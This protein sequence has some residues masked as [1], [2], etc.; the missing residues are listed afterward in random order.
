MRTAQHST[1][2][3]HWHNRFL[4]GIDELCRHLQNEERFA[5]ATELIRSIV[6]FHRATMQTDSLG[7]ASLSS[8][9]FRLSTSISGL[10]RHEDS[11]TA[12]REAIHL[13]RRAFS[14]HPEKYQLDFAK[15]LYI[16]GNDLR[17]LG[18]IDNACLVTRECVTIVHKLWELDSSA[19]HNDLVSILHQ[20]YNDLTV[21]NR[22]DEAAPLV[23]EWVAICKQTHSTSPCSYSNSSGLPMPSPIFRAIKKCESDSPSSSTILKQP[24]EL[25]QVPRYMN[26]VYM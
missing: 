6:L 5:E 2:A 25:E 20:L 15:A 7:A 9:L 21:L 11:C 26:H 1:R 24:L 12:R 19:Y 23:K 22:H 17:L 18:E 8:S 3:D 13:Y 14:I 10:R 4:D 16:L